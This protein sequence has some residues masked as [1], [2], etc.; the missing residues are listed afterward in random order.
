MIRLGTLFS[1]IGAIEQA[2]KLMNIS[3]TNVF[4]CDNGELELKLLPDPLQAEYDKLKKIARYRITQEEMA[5]LSELTQ[6]EQNIIEEYVKKIIESI[7]NN[8]IFS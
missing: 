1:G 2:L 8:S 4:A 6:K 5:R 3:H 7:D